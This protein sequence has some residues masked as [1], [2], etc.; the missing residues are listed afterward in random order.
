MG[1]HSEGVPLKTV[2]Q[3]APQDPAQDVGTV[4][5]ENASLPSTSM[6][7]IMSANIYGSTNVMIEQDML[8]PDRRRRIS[9]K[10]MYVLVLFLDLIQIGFSFMLS[11]LHVPDEFSSQKVYT[12]EQVN[13]IVLIFVID[14]V[15]ASFQF[16]YVYVCIKY[17][18]NVE[19]AAQQP[20]EFC[21]EVIQAILMFAS[22]HIKMFG[23]Q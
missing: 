21:I 20:L 16:L 17:F 5:N 3:P 13:K 19:T 6:S 1:K 14:H 9:Y 22:F 8:K 10:N 11:Q 12:M 7:E 2:K 23:R 4:D 18:P 15:P